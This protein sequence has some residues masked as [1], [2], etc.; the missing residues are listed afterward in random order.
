MKILVMSFQMALCNLALNSYFLNINS[1]HSMLGSK[2]WG[3]RE[4]AFDCPS[5]PCYS[6]AKKWLIG[7]S[8]H[9]TQ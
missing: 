8:L 6:S 9:K 7:P 1:A 2:A 4:K 3:E 5:S